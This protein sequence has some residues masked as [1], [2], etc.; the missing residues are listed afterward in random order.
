[1]HAEKNG[2]KEFDVDQ[3][4]CLGDLDILDLQYFGECEV[5]KCQ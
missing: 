2:W 4:T 5:S 3:V 1:M